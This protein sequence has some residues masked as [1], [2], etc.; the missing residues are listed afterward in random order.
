M[1][2]IVQTL[3]ISGKMMPEFPGRLV[4][5]A[6]RTQKVNDDTEYMNLA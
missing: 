1:A 4:T 6:D 3:H 2:S 5:R